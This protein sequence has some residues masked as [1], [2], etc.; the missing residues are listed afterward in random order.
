MRPAIDRANLGITSFPWAAAAESAIYLKN[1]LAHHR[2]QP[3][4]QI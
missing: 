3:S 1:R 2:Q 4:P